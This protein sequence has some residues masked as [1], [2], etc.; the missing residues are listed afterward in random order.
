[1]SLTSECKSPPWDLERRASTS[2]HHGGG[3]CVSYLPGAPDYY[4]VDATFARSRTHGHGHGQ[5]R[6]DP[7][8]PRTKEACDVDYV[9]AFGRMSIGRR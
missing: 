8:E 7:V 3:G 2:L 6:Y 4:M 5:P 1:M 9:S